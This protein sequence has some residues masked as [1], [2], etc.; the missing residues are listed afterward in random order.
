MKVVALLALVVV[1]VVAV[2]FHIL[3]P[4]IHEIYVL[5]FD[6]LVL[7]A[8]GGIVRNKKHLAIHGAL[9]LLKWYLFFAHEVP[10]RHTSIIIELVNIFMLVAHIASKER[11]AR[12][13]KL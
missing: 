4:I 8:V 2:I 7:T 1:L 11:H 10:V 3:V 12:Q 6:V 13:K 5:S 9:F